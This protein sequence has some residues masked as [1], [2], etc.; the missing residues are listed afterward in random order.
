VKAV[1]LDLD[2]TLVPDFAAF[3]AAVDEVAAAAG[4]PEG[5]AVTLRDH[6]RPVWY[7]APVA[8]WPRMVGLSSWGAMWAAFAGAGPRLSALRAWAPE[9][10]RAAWAAALADHGADPAAAADLAAALPPARRARCAAYPEVRD[11]LAALA[12]LGDLRIAVVTN[13]LSDHQWLKLET[14]GLTGHVDVF[15]PSGAIGVAKPDPRV[16]EVTLER[17]GI[18]PQDAVMVGDNPEN[19]VDAARRAGLRAV[20]LDRAGAP[21]DG[22]ITSLAELPPLVARWRQPRLSRS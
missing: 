6:A 18:A 14:A 5:M 17:L 15:V 22:R 9:Y 20:L 8:R 2:D 16:Y 21:G 13:G 12:E 3:T 7:S 10:R 4:A 19:D 1:L 11:A